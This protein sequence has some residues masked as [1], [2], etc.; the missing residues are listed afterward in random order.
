M[1]WEMNEVMIL[2]SVVN[3]VSEGLA[4][5]LPRLEVMA[6]AGSLAADR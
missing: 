1:G 5:P 4:V 6:E 3:V 2:P